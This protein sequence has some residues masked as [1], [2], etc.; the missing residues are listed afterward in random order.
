MYGT[1]TGSPSGL[2]HPAPD[3]GSLSGQGVL[4]PPCSSISTRHPAP[5]LALTTAART[6]PSIQYRSCPVCPSVGTGHV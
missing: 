1:M 3:S 6:S 2:V 5:A 4:Y